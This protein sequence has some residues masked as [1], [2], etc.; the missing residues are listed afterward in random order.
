[1]KNQK[2]HQSSKLEAL[3]LD[4]E[5]CLQ[6]P[7]PQASQKRLEDMVD[8]ATAF[9]RILCED[10]ARGI[11]R[12]ILDLLDTAL[13]IVLPKL[14]QQ[15]Q[16]VLARFAVQEIQPLLLSRHSAWTPTEPATA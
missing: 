14:P 16:R 7:R 12:P 2:S 9:L 4:L 8:F 11:R 1:M 15:R 13:K 6:Q 3:V 5:A 10:S